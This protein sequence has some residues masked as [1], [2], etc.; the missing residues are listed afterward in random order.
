MKNATARARGRPPVDDAD[1]REY[2]RAARLTRA[3]ADQL[4]ELAA[5]LELTEGDV[6]RRALAAYAARKRREL[7]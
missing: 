4:A 6:L 1:R 2:V 3:E 7:A 5:R